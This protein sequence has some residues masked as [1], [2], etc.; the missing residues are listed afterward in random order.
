MDLE[1][2]GWDPPGRAGALRVGAREVVI[3][4]DPVTMVADRGTGKTSAVVAS[5][6]VMMACAADAAALQATA[7]VRAE[8]LEPTQLQWSPFEAVLDAV[9]A[10][11]ELRDWPARFR[12][13]YLDFSPV[14]GQLH[15]EDVRVMADPI[16]VSSQEATARMTQAMSDARTMAGR[17]LGDGS[18]LEQIEEGAQLPDPLDLLTIA[19][20]LDMAAEDLRQLRESAFSTWS[21]LEPRRE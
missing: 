18:V 10:Q 4:F 11:S 14:A 17:V 7:Q 2:I 13:R 21:Q 12:Q 6:V 20:R 1:A 8:L 19:H 5:T 9:A 15:S 3:R 16:A